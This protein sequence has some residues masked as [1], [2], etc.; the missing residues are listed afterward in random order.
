M[1]ERHATVDTV[2]GE[3]TLVAADDAVIGVYFPQHWTGA[4]RAGRGVEVDAQDDA[5]LTRAA[6]QLREYLAG[7][8]TEFALET[9]ADGDDFQCRVWKILDGIPFGET[10]TYGDI[11]AELGDKALARAVGKAVG[12]NPLSIIVG[13]HRV[14][15]ADG[16]L[17]GYAG[18]LRRKRFL[19]SLE[20]GRPATAGRLF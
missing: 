2:I 6:S 16:S 10:T 3:L 7:E 19:L 5:I 15:G 9:R 4:T 11:A 8:R 20:E 14:L 13:C 12:A 18:G 17:T 1:Y